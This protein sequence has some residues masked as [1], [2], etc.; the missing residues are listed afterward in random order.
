MSL[1]EEAPIEIPTHLADRAEE[2]RA[3]FV[4]ARGG[5]PFL[6]SSDGNTLIEWLEADIPV[7]PIL[8]AIEHVAARRFARRTRRPFALQDCSATLKKLLKGGAIN[9][10][11]SRPLRIAE[12]V[13]APA[14]PHGELVAQTRAAL[15]AIGPDT[16]DA[17]ARQ[18]CEI[19]RCFHEQVWDRSTS[20][21]AVLM[22]EAAEELADLREVLGAE[23]FERV[24][25]ERARERLRQRYPEFSAT[26]I[27]EA[28]CGV[29]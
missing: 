14:D 15:L 4:Q 21:R 10:Y 3:W 8:R 7:T 23:S 29:E 5:A 24:C 22:V 1:Q 11:S 28:C 12:T 19:V 18:A 17:R 2:V 25:E 26:R 6:S 13:A 16:P 20:A 27:W 9:G